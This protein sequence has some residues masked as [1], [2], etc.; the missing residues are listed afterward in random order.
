M[1]LLFLKLDL[2]LFG[3]GCHLGQLDGQLRVGVGGELQQF[4][5]AFL[6]FGCLFGALS[7]QLLGDM[8]PLVSHMRLALLQ[9]LPQILQLFLLVF[10]LFALLFQFGR[11]LTQ[12]RREI[13]QFALPLFELDL[14]LFKR[15]ASLLVGRLILFQRSAASGNLLGFFLQLFRGDCKLLL[16]LCELGDLFLMLGRGHLELMA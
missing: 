6:Q 9:L 14:K 13:I 15:L 16:L 12:R 4:G 2:Q 10:D 8:S 3:S 7:P 11:L 1:V 5:A